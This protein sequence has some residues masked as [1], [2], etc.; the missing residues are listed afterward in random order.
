MLAEGEVEE[1]ETTSTGL[2]KTFDYEEDILYTRV[3]A[4]SLV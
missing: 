2:R 1:E 3:V 4:A